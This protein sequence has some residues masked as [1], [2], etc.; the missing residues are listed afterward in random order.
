MIAPTD[1]DYKSTKRVKIDG[2]PL[3]PVF[4]QLAQWVSARYDVHVLNVILDTIQPNNRPRL[5]VVLEWEL[6]ERKFREPS[7][8]FD[9][10]KQRE[11]RDKFAS[12]AGESLD[13]GTDIG[14]LLV[15][16]SSFESVARRE[17]NWKVPKED[18]EQLKK[19]LDWPDLWHVRRGFDAVTFFFCTDAQ[20]KANEASGSRER[21][22]Q[23]YAKLIAPYDEFGYVA[24][25]PIPVQLDSKE[26]FDSI[27]KG[28]W[29]DYDMGH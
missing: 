16:F 25:R 11:V 24:R 10:A 7:T 8:N 9:A 21:F 6:D 13:R 23:A 22:A 26:R 15:V 3:P 17:A 18:I 20:A 2:T 14:R 1:E 29:F 5:N 12:I 27:Y 28:S 4:R 19:T